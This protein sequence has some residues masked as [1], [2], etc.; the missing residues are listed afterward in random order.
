MMFPSSHDITPGNL[1]AC[2]RVIGNLL[3]SGNDLLIVSKPRVDCIKRICRDFEAFRDNIMFRFTIG[4][5]DNNILKF[6]EPNAPSY[7]ERHESLRLAFFSNFQTSVSI[8][9]VLDPGT[10]IELVEDLTPFVTNAIWIGTMNHIQKNISNADPETAE[11]LKSMRAQ[12]TEKEVWRIYNHLKNMDKIK[13][14][15]SIKKIVGIKLP[16]KKG[17]DE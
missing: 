10:V 11:A 14:K 16:N 8:E 15:E 6:W 1:D 7:E 13:W 2:G 4:A 5:M 9:P 17:L 12:Q 3:A